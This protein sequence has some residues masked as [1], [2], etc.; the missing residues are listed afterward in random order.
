MFRTL[1]GSLANIKEKDMKKIISKI[2]SALLLFSLCPSVIAK[3]AANIGDWSVG[4]SNTGFEASINYSTNVVSFP[5]GDSNSNGNAPCITYNLKTPIDLTQGLVAIETEITLPKNSSKRI[6]FKYNR[7]N[8]LGDLAYMSEERGLYKLFGIGGDSLNVVKGAE[9][10]NINTK[11]SGSWNGIYFSHKNDETL[12]VKVILDNKNARFYYTM[13]DGS[14]NKYKGWDDEKMYRPTKT[15]ADGNETLKYADDSNGDGVADVLKSISVVSYGS[16]CSIKLGNMK[17]YKV[18]PLTAELTEYKSTE[19]I[20]INFYGNGL[21]NADFSECAKLYAP[22]GKFVNTENSFGNGVLKM[23]AQK[24]TDCLGEYKVKLDKTK[25][26]ALGFRYTSEEE[27]AFSVFGTKNAAFYIDGKDGFGGVS[28]Y[29]KSGSAKNVS[30]IICEKDKNGVLVECK[31][32]KKLIA[33]NSE[34]EYEFNQKIADEENEFS[35]FAWET[36]NIKPLSE[37]LTVG[38][39]TRLYV[40]TD[41]DDKN[42]GSVDSPFKTLQRAR[43]EIRAT[44]DEIGDRGVTVYFR[45]G[46]YFFDSH[47]RI[48]RVDSGKE[49]APIIY[50]AYPGENV[51]FTGG[52]KIDKNDFVKADVADILSDK[53]KADKIVQLNIPEEINL[54]NELWRGAYSYNPIM[55]NITGESG[56]NPVELFIDDKAM[57]VARYPNVGF[58]YTGEV[59]KTGAKPGH[60]S[61]TDPSKPNYVVPEDRVATPFEIRVND[62]R[63]KKWTGAENALLYGRWSDDW[64]D[65]TVPVG[66]IN[67]DVITSKYPALYGVGENRPFYIYNLLEEIDS[68]G[69]YYIDREKRIL[70]LYPPENFHDIYLS[71]HETSGFFTLYYAS[72]VEIRDIT[73]KCGRYRAVTISG[74]ENNLVENCEIYN[75]A[76][77]GVYIG[78]GQNNGVKNCVI[79]D[80]NRGV[81]LSGGDRET[82]VSGGNFVKNCDIYSNDRISKT[83]SPCVEVHGVGNIVAHNKIHEA[84][85]DLIELSGNENVIEYN[86]IYNGVTDSDDAGA[87]YSCRNATFRGNEIRYNYFHDIGGGKS[88][89]WGKQAIFLDDFMSSAHIYGNVFHRIGGAAV[90]LAGS[91]NV[92]ENNIIVDCQTAPTAIDAQRRYYSDNNATPALFESLE[93]VPYKGSVWSEKYPELLSY[94]GADGLLTTGS[95]IIIRNNI[96]YNAKEVL[97]DS[98]IKSKGVFED[99]IVFEENPGFSDY[100]NGDFSL[101]SNA[102]AYNKLPNFKNIPFKEI[103]IEK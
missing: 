82:L 46:E 72:N 86:E 60:W 69:E 63:V 19:P 96:I 20:C 8:D 43:N 70:Y 4:D 88:G 3:E 55:Q 35:L 5:K 38:K 23:K 75:F 31:S 87:L 77:H 28:V 64:L 12:R 101:N 29:N 97:V 93:A 1:E 48:D 6:D 18:E 44:K 74:G 41:G 53:S 32:Y 13:T 76:N 9:S 54:S 25:I 66:S 56:S 100:E 50:R 40:A 80:N 57:T 42:S 11:T 27:F 15:G 99:N 85:H 61:I 95:N 62:E 59:I 7:P 45:E 33:D 16:A 65:Q 17:I 81:Y 21:E 30:V 79:H 94:I 90:K 51:V 83:Y 36:D 58:L 67:A 24:L 26:E 49:N 47:V 2:L 34:S 71:V 84:E 91:D 37:K 14:G 22:N 103:G 78:G 98:V 39:M 92:V 52:Y 68:P 89:K 10:D 73:M 102:Y